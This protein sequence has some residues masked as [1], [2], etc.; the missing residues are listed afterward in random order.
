MRHC[1][2]TGPLAGLTVVLAL[3][4]AAALGQAEPTLLT[5]EWPPYQSEAGGRQS[6]IAI[7]TVRC[8]LGRMGTRYR[9]V[10][11]PWRR[12]QEDVRAGH[13]DGF[14]AASHSAERDTYAE[15]SLPIAPQVWTW[16]FPRGAALQPGSSDFKSKARVSATSGSNMATFLSRQGYRIEGEARGLEQLVVMLRA[17]RVDAVLANALTFQATLEAI[18][19]SAH[20]FDSRAERSEPLGVYFGRHFLARQPGFLENF[21]AHVPACAGR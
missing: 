8:I 16:Y 3:V 1:L 9:V 15:F 7:E 10:F 5:Q 21:N 17:G 4:P 18:G 11:L 20:S 2:L 19:Q 14:F 12:A 6:G 13:A